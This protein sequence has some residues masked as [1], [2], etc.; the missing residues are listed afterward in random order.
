MQIKISNDK[1]KVSEDNSDGQGMQQ[2]TGKTSKAQER[3]FQ[4]T[5]T[6]CILT[7]L[8]V[9]RP[10][11]RLSN[12][13]Q[14]FVAYLHSSPSFLPW[15]FLSIHSGFTIDHADIKTI[16]QKLAGQTKLIYKPV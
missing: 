1:T 12:P 14:L 13:T 10:R 3:I 6:V 8:V 7:V 15:N 4:V 5:E 11:I 9:T 16:N 2:G